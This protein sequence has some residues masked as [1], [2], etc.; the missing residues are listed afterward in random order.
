LIGQPAIDRNR[1]RL[2]QQKDRERPTEEIKPAEIGDDRRHRGGDDVA[3][4]R[5]HE[6]CQHDGRHH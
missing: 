5:H 3:V 2:G 4:R 1:H 6:N